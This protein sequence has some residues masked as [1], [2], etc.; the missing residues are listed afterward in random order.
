MEHN[1]VSTSQ[2]TSCDFVENKMYWQEKQLQ[3]DHYDVTQKAVDL[4]KK[5]G[6][7]WL[8]LDLILMQNTYFR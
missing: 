4:Q 3:K 7:F 5:S 8:F 6:S 1:V 2:E